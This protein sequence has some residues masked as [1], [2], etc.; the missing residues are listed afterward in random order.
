MQLTATM[1]FVDLRGFTTFAERPAAVRRRHDSST[2]ILELMTRRGVSI[3]AAP[4]S[5]IAATGP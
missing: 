3:Q 4:S 1:L 2:S 5:R